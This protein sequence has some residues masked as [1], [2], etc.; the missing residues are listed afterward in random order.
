[1][2]HNTD[3]TQRGPRARE[4]CASMGLQADELV[5]DHPYTAQLLNDATQLI[6]ELGTELEQ[7]RA[8]R[9][10]ATHMA[11]FLLDLEDSVY[12]LLGAIEGRGSDA[13]Q[14]A[15]RDRAREVLARLT[16]FRKAGGRV[17]PAEEVADG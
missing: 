11:G 3:S 16:D 9:A 1:M 10:R 15:V 5:R 2:G 7:L 17:V 4:L 8:G 6:G 12:G 14:A 13:T